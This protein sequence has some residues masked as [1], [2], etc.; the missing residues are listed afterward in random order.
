[1][2]YFISCSGDKDRI[3]EMCD[4]IDVNIQPENYTEIK[5]EVDGAGTDYAINIILKFD[6][7]NLDKLTKQIISSPYFN[8]PSQSDANSSYTKLLKDINRRGLWKKNAIG[9]EFVDYGSESEP[10]TV[11]I[12]T[13]KQTLDYTFVHL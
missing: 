7:S 6:N 12:D 5:N 10:V 13:T 8:S 2:S 11:L 4:E 3:K 1:M 9:Y